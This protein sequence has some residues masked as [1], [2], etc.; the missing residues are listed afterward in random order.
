MTNRW[1]FLILWCLKDG[2]L[3]FYELRDAVEGISER[4][5]SENLKKLGRDG[6]LVRSV[7]PTRPPKVSYTLTPIGEELTEVVGQLANWIDRRTSEI[8]KARKQYDQS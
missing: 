4:V 2:Q 3:R 7:E 1:A 6:L 8:E 5:L